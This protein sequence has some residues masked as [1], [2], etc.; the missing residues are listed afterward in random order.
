MYDIMNYLY[1]FLYFVFIKKWE[2][3]FSIFVSLSQIAMPFIAILAL[4]TWKKEMKG[5]NKY[6]IAKKLIVGTKK[7]QKMIQNDVRNPALH[8]AEDDKN[9]NEYNWMAH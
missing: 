5:G 4:N 8:P 6:N 2:S 7:V 9:Y 1:Q 3:F